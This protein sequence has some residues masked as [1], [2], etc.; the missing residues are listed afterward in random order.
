MKLE[1]NLFGMI[2]TEQVKVLTFEDGI[3]GFPEFTQFTLIVDE[4]NTNAKIFWLQS[5]NDG[6]FALPLVDPFAIFDSYNPIVEDDWFA[7]LGDHEEDDLLVFL[8]MHVPED[9]TK[10]TVNQK[11]PVILNSKTGRGCQIIVED[12]NYQVKCPVYDR[13]KERQAKEGD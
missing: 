4:E 3:V 6:T 5:L 7:T 13:L 1:T 12:E 9:I 11:A 10:M 2:D 8:T